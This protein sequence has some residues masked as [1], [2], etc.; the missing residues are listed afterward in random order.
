MNCMIDCETLGITPGCAIL[1][2]GARAFDSVKL[3][4]NFYVNVNL[5]SCLMAGL[6]VEQ[7]AVDFWKSPK[8][9]LARPFLWREPSLSLK[10]A[11]TNFSKWFH[12][13]DCVEVWSKGPAADVV[14]M[15]AAFRAVDV[16][17]PW[18]Y[19]KVRCVRTII[20]LAGVPDSELSAYGILHHAA[21]DASNQSA[22]VMKAMNLLSTN[23]G[24]VR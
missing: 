14:W 13:N 9:D 10:D 16:T 6:H 17:C 15:E 2:I 19:R 18:S 11:L 1:S 3:G 8:A 12:D 24:A 20:D 22:D 7:G 23:V 21:D 4:P 5:F